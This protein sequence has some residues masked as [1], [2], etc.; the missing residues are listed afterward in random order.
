M[1]I[2]CIYDYFGSDAR[3]LYEQY[4]VV[5]PY[6]GCTYTIRQVLHTRHGVGVYLNEL[7]NPN[8]FPVMPGFT[9]EVSFDINRFRN[10]DNSVIT[11]KQVREFLFNK[12]E[13]LV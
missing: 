4:G 8:N 7:I 5:T 1:E 11:E 13:Q 6:E 12:K 3:E 2:I 10:L 9:C